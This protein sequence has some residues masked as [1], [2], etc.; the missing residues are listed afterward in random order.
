MTPTAEMQRICQDKSTALLVLASAGSGKTSCSIQK[1]M[2]HVAE[3]DCNPEDILA[4]TFS[5]AAAIEMRERL[6]LAASSDIAAHASIKTFHGYGNSV[7]RNYYHELKRSA[8]PSLINETE[9]LAVLIDN[10]SR[11]DKK[12]GKSLLSAW[13][14]AKQQTL[15]MRNRE[16]LLSYLAQRGFPNPELCLDALYLFE[17]GK[18]QANVVDYD[19]LIR[20]PISLLTS[21][22][23]VRSELQR[24]NRLMLIDEFQ[25]TNRIQ[26]HLACLL[27][28]QNLEGFRSIVAIGDDD[29]SIY[30]WRGAST[31]NIRV[32]KDHFNAR[33][34]TL[35]Q[36]FRCP[37]P[38][39]AAAAKMIQHNTKRLPKQ[40]FSAIP[41]EVPQVFGVRNIYDMAEAIASNVQSWLS[42]HA[43]GKE[44]A[45]LYRTNRMSHSLEAALNQRGIAY[46]LE[47]NT[48]AFFERTEIRAL[49]ACARLLANTSDMMALRALQPY[50]KGVGKARMDGVIDTI[51]KNGGR[52]DCLLTLPESELPVAV[53]QV[54]RIV[55]ELM[56]MGAAP[57]REGL[58]AFTD[59]IMRTGP[60]SVLNH[61]SDLEM[62]RKREAN[63]DLLV[64]SI[65]HEM[66]ITD[67]DIWLD[68]LLNAALGQQPREHDI[69]GE[70]PVASRVVLC[71]IHNAKG[72]EFDSTI[73]AGMSENILPLIRSPAEASEEHLAE[74]RRLAF[75]A[76]TRTKGTLVIYHADTFNFPGSDPIPSSPSRFLK[77]AGLEIA[78]LDR[79]VSTSTDMSLET[80]T[81]ALISRMEPR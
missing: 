31:A 68:S 52:I 11:I 40:P 65:C 2:Y 34:A 17:E 81:Q 36:N 71:T 8:P 56:V 61:E 57:G 5:N 47:S 72:A 38:V 42:T 64:E 54:R 26:L 23:R 22:E 77:E 43:V 39:V 59:W 74:E 7:I 49:M 25:D 13:S 15:N 67:S 3:G 30:R 58:E 73:I 53:V 76:M 60:L 66:T 24:H 9:Q 4:L 63:V 6:M 45:I 27:F 70:G 48:V 29:Q 18:R 41:G 20:M 51:Q 78:Q 10:E 16:P 35:S 55:D 21:N 80:F 50:L 79:C 37:A 62:Q 12:L 75:V 69:D 14:Y 32:F 1:I 44:L 33:M 28:N 19:D 46:Q